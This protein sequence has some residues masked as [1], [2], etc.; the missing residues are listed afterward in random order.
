MSYLN[1]PRLTFSGQ[2]QADPSTVNNDPT[3]FDN[4]NFKASYQDYSSATDLNGWWNPDGTG[5]WRFI[6]CQITSV[7]YQDGTST[8]N[9]LLDPVIGM[10]VM[11]T[12]ARTAGK[13]VDLDSQQQMVSELW[14]FI[15]RI[16]GQEGTAMMKGEYEVAPFTNIWFNRSVDMTADGGAAAFYQSVIK[17]I[18]WDHAYSKSRY[19][20]ELREVSP[21]QLSIEFTVDRYDGNNTSPQF[22]LGRIAGAIGPHAATEPKHFVLGRQLASAGGTPT[23]YGVALVNEELGHLVLDLGNSLQFNVDGVVKAGDLRIGVNKG[24]PSDLAFVEFGKIGY[25]APGWYMKSSGICTFPL[26]AEQLQL[27]ITY[28]IVVAQAVTTPNDVFTAE[29]NTT[30]GFFLAENTQFVRADKF[31]FRLNPNDKCEIQFYAT[32]LGKPLPNAII[33]IQ[34]NTVSNSFLG[35]ASNIPSEPPSPAPAIGTPA[36]L[37]F[38]STV[39]V[40]ANTAKPATAVTDANGKATYSFVAPDPGNPRGYIDG[41]IYGLSYNLST[42]DFATDCNPENFVSL[43]IFSGPPATKIAPD[44]D[45]FMQPI[46]QQYANLYPL[47]SKGIFNLADKAVVDR[48]AQILKLVFSK[49]PHDPNYMP[50]TRDLSAYKKKVILDYLDSVTN[51]PAETIELYNK[52]S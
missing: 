42:Q 33:E 39:S 1:V 25:T 13:I 40:K 47:M 27:A 44:W 52:K 3:H 11:D 31:V 32:N 51:K 16:V 41:Q 17:N 4:A 8:D 10:S 43:L 36:L 2:F 46:M 23:N 21:K 35:P 24:T 12:D 22:T 7:T 38:P 6:G 50:A 29:T 5:N 28:P 45:N 48:N 34:D 14:G 15:V 49:D 18:T 9:P 26:T 20:N 19:L 37:M 30:Y